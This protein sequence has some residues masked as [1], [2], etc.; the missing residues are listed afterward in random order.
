MLYI[1]RGFAHGFCTMT[2]LSEVVYKVDNFYSPE[3]ERGIL[4]NDP[5]LAISWPVT[6]PF[7]SFKDS[8]NLSLKDLFN[9]PS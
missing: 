1:P 5:E 6:D 7:L 8:N 9:K 3:H 4:W 2:E